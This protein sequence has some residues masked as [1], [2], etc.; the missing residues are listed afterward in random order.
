MEGELILADMIEGIPH[1]GETSELVGHHQAVS[2]LLGQYRTGR[3]HHAILLSGPKGI[4]KVTLALKM[5]THIFAHPDAAY[6]PDSLVS[7]GDSNPVHSRIAAR[8]HPNLLHLTRPWDHKSKKFKT[9][10]TVDEIRQTVQFFGTARGESGWRVAIVDA[11]DEMNASASNALLKILEEPPDRTIFFIIAHSMSSVMPTIRSRCQHMPLKPL[12]DDEVLEVLE[13]QNV[14]DGL[15]AEQRRHLVELSGGSVRRAIILAREEGLELYDSFT[16]ICKSLPTPD[17]GEIQTLADKVVARG[18]E[19]R[20]R[21]LLNFAYEFMHQNA[22]R[23]PSA[24]TA[25]SSLA[26][27]AEVWEKTR[28]SVRTAE[29]YNLD[30]KQV[31]LNLFHEMGEAER[32]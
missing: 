5:A 2:S 14:L 3:M 22:T 8:S 4:G 19:D 6:A 13:T 30:R 23:I 25:I 24:E 27:W 31:I 16:A 20:Y 26:R 17:W 32:A 29:S 1:P 7:M 15:D 12:S 9:R 28:D 18:K 11:L 10:L 21:L